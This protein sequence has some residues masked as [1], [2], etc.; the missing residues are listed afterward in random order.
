MNIMCDC[1]SGSL[2]C[3]YRKA[4]SM[5]CKWPKVIESD[6]AKIAA[7]KPAEPLVTVNWPDDNGDGSAGESRIDQVARSHGD[8]EHYGLIDPTQVLL[9]SFN[10]LSQVEA[11]WL[12]PDGLT[13]CQAMTRMVG[14]L[15]D[16]HLIRARAELTMGV[17]TYLPN[18]APPTAPP[19]TPAQ[20]VASKDWRPAVELLARIR[21]ARAAR[22]TAYWF[23]EI[24]ATLAA[25]KGD[26]KQ[27]AATVPAELEGV[28]E[29]IAEG[30]GFWRSCSGCHET[31]DGHPMGNYVTSA[32]LQ[33]DLGAGCSECGGLGAVWDSTD[34]SET[35]ELLEEEGAQ[36]PAVEV[37]P[38]V[39]QIKP[40]PEFLALAEAN[41]ARITGKPD[42]SEAIE[43][44]FSIQVWRAFDAAVAGM[45]PRVLMRGELVPGDEW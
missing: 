23:D 10:E 19:T 6:L 22:S 45:T 1:G 25:Y 18:A 9:A 40:R 43:I 31:E 39:Q 24:D 2:Q 29:Q 32:V 44:V 12:T 17:E 13:H 15:D 20:D 11:E 35:D 26:A 42:G 41:G 28:A 37:E 21:G 27:P 14:I 33:C 7:M 38:A 3:T 36:Q 8:G 34:Y 16:I 30:A 5:T 4:V